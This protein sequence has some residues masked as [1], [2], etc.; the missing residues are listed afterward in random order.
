MHHRVVFPFAGLLLLASVAPA[1]DIP[2]PRLV[3]VA[4]LVAQLRSDS[5]AEREAAT[6]R[7]SALEVVPA[8]LSEA[9]QSPSASARNMTVSPTPTRE[10]LSLPALASSRVE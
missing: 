6:K 1:D 7:L 5:L 9:L 10:R 3:P 4:A 8:E 2:P